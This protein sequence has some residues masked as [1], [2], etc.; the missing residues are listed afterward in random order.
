ML[1]VIPAEDRGKMNGDRIL[2]ALTQ[3]NAFSIQRIFQRK[4]LVA[5]NERNTEVGIFK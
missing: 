4:E 2:T 5:I 1:F 3:R